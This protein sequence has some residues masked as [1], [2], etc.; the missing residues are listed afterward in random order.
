MEYFS[1]K[2]RQHHT[3][4]LPPPCL[5]FAL[6]FLSILIFQYQNTLLQHNLLFVQHFGSVSNKIRLSNIFDQQDLFFILFIYKPLLYWYIMHTYFTKSSGSFLE[7]SWANFWYVHWVV[8]IRWLLKDLC[9][10]SM[11]S[12]LTNKAPQNASLWRY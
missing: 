12:A 11:R 3:I 10:F 2:A 4:T 6:I 1:K 8:L 9:I 5:T 7:S